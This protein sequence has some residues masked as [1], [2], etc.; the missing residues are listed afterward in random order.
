MTSRDYTFSYGG[1]DWTATV[2]ANGKHF[3]MCE[4]NQ[5]FTVGNEIS[6]S[7]PNFTRHYDSP[8]CSRLPYSSISIATIPQST[9]TPAVPVT[10]TSFRPYHFNTSAS[11]LDLDTSS[12]ARS[13]HS[14]VCSIISDLTVTQ[15]NSQ[16]SSITSL[17]TP[18][19]ETRPHSPYQ[20]M[21]DSTRQ[22]VSAS[23]SDDD[24]IFTHAAPSPSPTVYHCPGQLINWPKDARISNTYPLH[25]Q[26][27]RNLPWNIDAIV[28]E[29][30]TITL[31]D[32]ECKSDRPRTEE[33]VCNRCCALQSNRQLQNLMRQAVLPS[34]KA[35][36]AYKFLN[37]NQIVALL[38][39]VSR[40]LEKVRSQVRIHLIKVCLS[41]SVSYS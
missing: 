14:R 13:T 37:W 31:R 30:N 20:D 11:S 36:T 16:M 24:G 2:G 21:S 22:N 9:S 7:I 29:D 32:L 41:E 39:Q 25:A 40:K 28:F 19:P 17:A 35:H 1:R 6:R 8:R 34:A 15:Y 3:V 12:S 27:M 38:R 4:C 10:S 26:E 5:A 18:V 23:D 33:G